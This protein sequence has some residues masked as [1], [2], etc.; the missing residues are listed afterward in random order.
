MVPASFRGQ[1]LQAMTRDGA[2]LSFTREVIKGVDY[3]FFAAA[4]GGFTATYAADTT[5]PAIS[6]VNAVAATDGTA[7]VSWT[8]NEPSD[9]RVDYGT[10]AAL[11][12][13]ASDAAAVTAH[14][15]VLTGLTPGASYSYRVR[16]A[17]GAGNATTSPAPAEP[18][19]TFGVPVTRSPAA[20]V[21]ETGT[22]RGGNAASLS[23]DDDVYYRVNSSTS[24]TRT[25]SWYGSFTG[26]PAGLSGLKVTYTGRNSR[27]CTQVIAAWRWTDSTWQQ[28]NSGTVGN[29]DTTRADL[30]PPGAPS[31]YVSPTGELR[32]RVRCTTTAS[33][34]ASGD[35]LRVS[36]TP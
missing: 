33:F 34:F 17:D 20:T 15:V 1:T 26:V 23:A 13:S 12:Q 28:L 8:T 9:S 35:L 29:T 21:I 5:A 2:P 25:S 32:V 30:V 31:G 18:A 4:A 27:N 6:A 10:S 3:A 7:A 24:G 22:L 19:A 16:S 11:G 36:Y 14:R